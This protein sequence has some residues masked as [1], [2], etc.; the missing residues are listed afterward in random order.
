MVKLR[1]KDMKELA[2]R[3]CSYIVLC[4]GNTWKYF[5]NLDPEVKEL[6]QVCPGVVWPSQ[7]SQPGHR[8]ADSC[9][10]PPVCAISLVKSP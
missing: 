9:S 4:I 7:D 10:Y 2:L 6:V 1:L 8:A 5:L 3:Q